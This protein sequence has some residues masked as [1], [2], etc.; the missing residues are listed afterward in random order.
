MSCEL[1]AVD[2]FNQINMLYGTITE[3]CSK[4]EC[5]VMTAGPRCVCPSATSG[6]VQGSRVAR[7]P[8]RHGTA[9]HCAALRGIHSLARRL[10]MLME[11]AM[12]RRYEY[13][14]QDGVNFKKPTKLSAPGAFASPSNEMIACV[15]L[16]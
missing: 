9:M 16:T 4:E 8:A 15:P 12:K 6:Q 11:T 7:R 1:A 3:F 5:P 10:L 14:W 2:F 13:H